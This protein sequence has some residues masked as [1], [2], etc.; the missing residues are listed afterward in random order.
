MLTLLLMRHAKSDREAGPWS[1]HERPLARRG[2]EA[3]RLIGE[4]LTASGCVPDLVLSSSAERAR[5]TAELAREAG[6]WG[7][8]MLE[9]DALYASRPERV[10]ETVRGLSAE[11]S[12]LLLVGHEPVWSELLSALIGGG[13]F[14][15]PTAAVAAVELAIASWAD[16]APAKGQLLWLV[17]PR[18]LRPIR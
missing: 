5:R 8:S 9:S 11:P 12:N 1:D 10:I 16:L 17:T 13:S 6:G 15:F 4:V 7:C 2:V 18:L 3:A 14:R